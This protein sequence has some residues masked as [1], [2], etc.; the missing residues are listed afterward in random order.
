MQVILWTRQ[1]L[2]L[3]FVLSQPLVAVPHRIHSTSRN[4]REEKTRSEINCKYILYRVCNLTM[5]NKISSC[6]L[7]AIIFAPFSSKQFLCFRCFE[8]QNLI[9]TVRILFSCSWELSG[10]GWGCVFMCYCLGRGIKF[11]EQAGQK[12]SRQ[13]SLNFLFGSTCLESLQKCP[14]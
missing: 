11:L 6:N 8:R 10:G 9:K 7:V 1:S 4:V 13:R 3:D 14:F 5:K 12:E 2:V